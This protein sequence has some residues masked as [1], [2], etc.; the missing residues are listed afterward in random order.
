MGPRGPGGGQ[1]AGWP[2]QE[3]SSTPASCP[4]R[5]VGKASSGHREDAGPVEELQAAQEGVSVRGGGVSGAGPKGQQEPPLAGGPGEGR[6]LKRRHGD[7]GKAGVAA[8]RGWRRGAET[9]R[10][11][12][13]LW[14]LGEGGCP[15]ERWQ[16]AWGLGNRAA[17]SPVPKPQ[18]FLGFGALGVGPGGRASPWLQPADR[19][20]APAVRGH[21]LGGPEG[22]PGGDCGRPCSRTGVQAPHP[23][24]A[25]RQILQCFPG[26]CFNLARLPGTP[27]AHGCLCLVAGTLARLAHT[28][29]QVWSR[30]AR[31]LASLEG[32][33]LG[34]RQPSTP[35]RPHPESRCIRGTLS[36][37]PA[38]L[39]RGK[40][41]GSPRCEHV[42]PPA[43]VT[44]K[45]ILLSRAFQVVPASFGPCSA[46]LCCP[47]PICVV[48]RWENR[49]PQTPRRGQGS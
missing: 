11:G 20:G 15:G 24:S 13:V 42:P 10:Q 12:Q 19:C 31:C 28:G 1:T 16:L 14:A 21:P 46:H 22:T 43:T 29:W 30:G 41:G 35:G 18:L 32:R 37:S 9:S 33:D 3:G 5:A 7:T 27:H 48:A 44:W 36:G 6:S 34:R 40:G 4:T 49:A 26:N 38:V 47:D 25:T 39:S 45:T 23:H 8:Q 17:I 2:S